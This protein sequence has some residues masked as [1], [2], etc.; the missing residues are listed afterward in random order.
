MKAVNVFDHPA[1]NTTCVAYLLA[2]I[3][4]YDIREAGDGVVARLYMRDG[5]WLD[6]TGVTDVDSAFAAIH[7]HVESIA[8]IPAWYAAEH[9]AAERAA[10]DAV[11][12][13]FS[14]PAS[15]P[16]AA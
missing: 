7:Q 11:R 8:H 1:G 14:A 5:E 15:L 12:A 6:L 9:D 16:I 3:R 4:S 2:G 13:A 10:A